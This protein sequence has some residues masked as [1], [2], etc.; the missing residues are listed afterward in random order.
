MTSGLRWVLLPAL[1]LLAATMPVAAVRGDPEVVAKQLAASLVPELKAAPHDLT[2]LDFEEELGALPEGTLAVL[3]LYA[4]WCP[5]C[6][7]FKPTFEKLAAFFN[8]QPELPGPTVWV[9]RVDCADEEN[10][11][12]V[13]STFTALT[14]FPTMMWGSPR[15]LAAR[16]GRVIDVRKRDIEGILAWIGKQTGQEYRFE[17]AELYKPASSAPLRGPPVDVGA[18]VGEDAELFTPRRRGPPG[19]LQ[20]V[21][22]EQDVQSAT[23]LGFSYIIGSPQLLGLPGARAALQGWVHLL[24][25]AHPVRMCRAGSVEL[26]KRFDRVWPVGGSPLPALSTFH[27]CGTRASVAPWRGCRGSQPST[28]GFTCGVWSLLHSTAAHLPE[29]GGAHWVSAVRGYIANF[30]QCSD[31]SKHFTARISKPDAGEVATRRDAV[32]WIWG[33]H[34]EVNARLAKEEGRLG[35]GDPLFPKSLWPPAEL[36]PACHGPGADEA[37]GVPEWREEEVYNF[38]LQFY[39]APE[40]GD[41]PGSMVQLIQRLSAPS[42]ASAQA[43]LPEAALHPGAVRMHGAQSP[44]A[45]PPGSDISRNNMLSVAS[46]CLVVVTLV[47][48]AVRCQGMMAAGQARRN[49]RADDRTK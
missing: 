38:L 12:E 40:A 37:A 32:L 44:V 4:S 27:V 6:Q 36:C 15:E 17:E 25:A 16:G 22:D 30:F 3:E 43:P 2:A 11:K 41:A 29:D 14:G 47:V 10:N 1:L 21:V 9:G 48:L 45:A 31:C 13:C 8:G 42:D 26:A 24:A 23:L 39:G 35:T 34:N 5:A 46:G 19:R 7:H 49:G 18:A 20:K 28:R 33:V